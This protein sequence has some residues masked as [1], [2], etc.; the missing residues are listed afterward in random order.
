MS[1]TM[2]LCYKYTEKV[3]KINFVI[4]AVHMTKLYAA[5]LL[6]LVAIFF[7]LI[8]LLVTILPVIIHYTWVLLV[9]CIGFYILVVIRC[10]LKAWRR[11]KSTISLEEGSLL[12]CSL[13]PYYICICNEMEQE[14]KDVIYY[15]DIQN[16]L[17]VHKYIFILSK[18][19]KKVLAAVIPPEAFGS[20]QE[21]KEIKAYLKTA[22]NR[23]QQMKPT[24]SGGILWQ[25]RGIKTFGRYL[26]Y[27]L[28]AVIAVVLFFVGLFML[29][30]IVL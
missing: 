1:E 30:E 6:A 21:Y 5:G 20:L 18:R 28:K 19:D 17:M 10:H 11:Y 7:T 27:F 16:I 29:L 8:N 13:M 12:W 22:I 26:W 14:S 24:F 2:N 25:S 15:S 4:L 23:P 3:K 9:V